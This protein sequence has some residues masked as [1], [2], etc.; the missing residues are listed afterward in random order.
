M[1]RRKRMLSTSN[2]STIHTGSEEPTIRCVLFHLINKPRY[3]LNRS[4]SVFV[5]SR[6]R[7][8]GAPRLSRSSAALVTSTLG[9]RCV[10]RLA[11]RAAGTRPVH[12]PLLENLEDVRDCPVQYE[13]RR[14]IEEHE[15][16][17]EG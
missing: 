11:R 5:S 17:N 8:S 9:P 10:F 7:T 6:C 14:E 12:E 4:A 13:P 16:E 1:T 15:R 2:S 3:L